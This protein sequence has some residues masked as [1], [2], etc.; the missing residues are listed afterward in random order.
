MQRRDALGVL[1][2][3]RRHADL[4]EVADERERAQMVLALHACADDRKDA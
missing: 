1:A 2:V 3:Q 4:V